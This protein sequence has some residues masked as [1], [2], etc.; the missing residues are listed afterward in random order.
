MTLTCDKLVQ[1]DL[2]EEAEKNLSNSNP[3]MLLDFLSVVSDIQSIDRFIKDLP[4]YPSST[5]KI[6]RN[7]LLS[8]ISGTLAIEG[9]FLEKEE[10]EKAL[11]KADMGIVLQ[12]KEQEA[13]NSKK[14]YNFIIEF[15][16]THK[17]G[18]TLSEQLIRQIHT[19][20]LENMNY[21]SSKGG[22]YR[23]NFN[24]T[25]GADRK[26]SLCRT[27]DEIETAMSN[28]IDWLNKPT[29]GLLSGNIF[30][31]AIMAHYYL[32]EIHPFGDGN[33]RTAR[34]L[35]AMMLLRHN[36]NYYCFW[37][38][39]NFWSANKDQY[40]R[41]LHNIRVTL[42][43]IDFVMWGLKGYREELLKIKEKVLRKVKQLMLRDYI[44]YLYNS[45]KGQP[46]EKRI[47]IRIMDVLFLLINKGRVPLKK[48]YSEETSLIYKK[49][50]PSTKVRDLQRML[51]NGLVKIEKVEEIDYIEP[52]FQILG[53]VTYN[54]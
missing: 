2:L 29:S 28:F 9:T 23:N 40:I 14:V 18:F 37:S 41:E 24:V 13:E 34:A 49:T 6:I 54:V 32:T 44:R 12:R 1:F 22:E 11:E 17:D 38:L 31:R 48:F 42:N 4:S 15:V 47:N 21:L 35:E 27:K 3:V 50:S 52:E 30:A 5:D 25:F 16:Q 19:Y 26:K 45:R 39:A 43:P 10:V 51:A 46:I 53:R 8:I 20:F 33:G 36:I 7:E